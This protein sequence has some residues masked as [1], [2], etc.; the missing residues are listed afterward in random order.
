[1]AHRLSNSLLRVRLALVVGAVAA[2][3]TAAP[4]GA[5]LLTT[6]A[7]ATCETAASQPFIP[8]SDYADYVLVSGGSFESG[9]PGWTLRNGA[10]V[11]PGNETFY[12]GDAADASSLLLLPGS[13]A[14]TPTTCFALGDWHLRFFL[15]KVGTTSGSVKVD[16][17]VK[18]LLGVASVLDGGSVSAGGQW[19]PSPR[20]ALLLSNVTSLL[21][22]RAVAFRFRASG[23]P[24]QLDDVYLD[25][26]KSY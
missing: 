6:G 8:W 11:V 20:V 3:V 5:G 18:S 15:R 10:F 21:G 24:F 7:A 19:T 14:I 23:A 2:A 12:A 25:P 9:A 4:A 16:V 22:T 17:V 1:M 13:S 26:W